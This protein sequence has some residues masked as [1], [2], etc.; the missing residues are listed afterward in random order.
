VSPL[1]QKAGVVTFKGEKEALVEAGNNLLHPHG[2]GEEEGE[3]RNQKPEHEEI[4]TNRNDE[5]NTQKHEKHTLSY[6]ICSN[7]YHV[8]LGAIT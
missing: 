8:G 7:V 1:A 2:Q 3:K 4:K 6:F 5:E